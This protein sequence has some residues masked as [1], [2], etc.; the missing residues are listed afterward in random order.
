MMID[1]EI[2]KIVKA[3]AGIT[4]TGVHKIIVARSR[5]ARWF[6]R[7]SVLTAIFGPGYTKVSLALH[8][9]ETA[10]RI[11]SKWEARMPGRQY[12][13]RQYYEAP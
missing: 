8:R 5:C 1:D 11:W 7:E 3:N 2:L 6:G 4:S 12:R 13:N 9:L 10:R